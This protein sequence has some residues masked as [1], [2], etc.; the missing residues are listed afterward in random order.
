[1]RKIFGICDID[2]RINSIGKILLDELT[3]PFYLFQLYSI[4]LWYCTEYYYYASVIVALTIISLILSVYG[5]YQNLKQLQTISKY[6]CPVKVYRKNENNEL[7]GQLKWIQ[8]NW[9]LEIYLKF[10]KMN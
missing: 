6:S 10:Q 1:M 3:D 9:S 4:I 8:L 2:I 5:T 7:M